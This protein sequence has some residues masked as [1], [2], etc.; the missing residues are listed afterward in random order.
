[1]FLTLLAGG[2][3]GIASSYVA[4]IYFQKN[5]NKNHRPIIEVSKV[6]IEKPSTDSTNDKIEIKLI[7]YTDKDISNIHIE[8]EGIENLSHK[9]SIPLLKLTPI[10]KKD[11]L[12][13][14]EYDK[15]DKKFFHNAHR[16]SLARED[17]IITKIK[18]CS[19][20]K[21]SIF[22]NCPY[23]GTS[24]VTSIVYNI[25]DDLLSSDYSFNTGNTVDAHNTK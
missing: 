8:V 19:D 12:Y 22:A 15:N 18:G 14:S 1:M 24:I 6:L 11:I 17:S 21:V 10:S 5:N 25:K 13:I 7:N 9:D 4:S 23:Y 16:I 20:I 3:I 2:I